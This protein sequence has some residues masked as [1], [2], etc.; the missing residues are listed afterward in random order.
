MTRDVVE[1]ILF[2][3]KGEVLLQKKTLDYQFHP[4]MWG[5]FGGEIE[6]NENE[7]DAIVREFYEETGITINPKF[8][9]S[10]NYSLGNSKIYIAKI[11]DI[12]KISLKEGAGFAVIDK[13]ELNDL[14][15]NNFDLETL[16]DFFQKNG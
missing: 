5:L 2:N 10:R 11:N 7:K 16:I 3:K 12:S 13:R 15:I 4:G 9:R 8:Y 6:D 1:C 14:K